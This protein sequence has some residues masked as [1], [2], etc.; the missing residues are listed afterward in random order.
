MCDVITRLYGPISHRPIITPER[1]TGGP[2]NRC[3]PAPRKSGQKEG[4]ESQD[5]G[6]AQVD[7]LRGGDALQTEGD[8]RLK[9]KHKHNNTNGV[10]YC[11]Q[12]VKWGGQCRT[13]LNGVE[14]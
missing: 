8:T 1:V 4:A 10:W 6:S 7:L 14:G 9:E 2:V 13:T 12:R 3:Y 11:G 5:E